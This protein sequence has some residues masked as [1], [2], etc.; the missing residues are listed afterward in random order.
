MHQPTVIGVHLGPEP[1]EPE[2][3]MRMW[4]RA[5]ELGFGWISV[6][7]HFVPGMTALEG[8]YD[9]VVSHTALA[10]STSRAT[11]GALVY[12]VTHRNIGVLAN[13]IATIDRFSG[14]RAAL[15]IGAGWSATEHRMFGL[16]FDSA[17]RRLDWL[18]EAVPCLRRL[19]DSETVTFSGEHVQL[20]DA[21]IV[22]G[23][24][25]DHLPIWVG[26]TGERRTLRIAAQHADGWNSPA[27]L[28]PEEFA[29][30]VRVLH[31]HCDDVARDPS[32]IRCAA[33]ILSPWTVENL[34]VIADANSATARAD[35]EAYTATYRSTA[36]LGSDEE[37]RARIDAFIEAGADQV[38]F[39]Y[40]PQWGVEGLE[41]IASLVDL[42]G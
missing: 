11:V 19:F 30:K 34:A 6:W 35:F 9:A 41:R 42:S 26:G 33:N 22:P 8:S 5:D 12:S 39:S 10:L 31:A 23:P 37:A 13:A 25:N 27:G 2:L 21:R 7:D 14:G 38:N 40:L 24:L 1:V 18:Q 28:T 32:T 4:R 36:L 16:P 17:G 29:L 20:D 3:L 15:G